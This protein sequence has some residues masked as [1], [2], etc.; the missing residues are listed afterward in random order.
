M[1]RVGIL[2]GGQ[3]GMLLAN[4]IFTLGGRVNVFDPDPEAPACNHVKNSIN[5]PWMNYDALNNFFDISD[6][7]TYE[8]EN[9]ESAPLVS[10]GHLKPIYPS[11]KVLKTCQDR[12]LEKK[13]L[14][15]AGLPHAN[16]VVADSVAHL[17]AQANHIN[18]PCIVKTAR[19]GYDGKGQFKISSREEY[20][21]FL[22]DPKND[23][24]ETFTGVV[25]EVIEL[26]TE[27]S[28]I[29]ARPLNGAPVAFPILENIHKEHILDVTVLPARIPNSVQKKIKEIAIEAATKLD[30]C[31]LLTTEFFLSK[32]KSATSPGI[33][34]DGWYIYINE[35]APRPH[36]SGHVT[37]SACCMSQY[38]AL[39]RILLD[40]PL[41]EPLV[42]STGTFC[43]MNLLG[44]V[45]LA[46]GSKDYDAKL[47]LSALRD[48]PQVLDVVIYGK[49]EPR[50]KRK[51]GHFITYGKTPESAIEAAHAF[52]NSLKNIKV[53]AS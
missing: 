32:T 45:W 2:G 18:F 8:F 52:R 5:F 24:L 44:D 50:A 29:V 33:E 42:I 7:V 26:E 19:G 22:D 46:Q 3:L 28:C 49:R 9:V 17:R 16:F 30:V 14:L 1:K 41:Q 48:H 15:A 11:V 43:M 37:T 40:V 39:A 21:A 31:G 38:D 12:A 10:L 23:W 27:V 36:N 53:T 6:V 47:D 4:S 51:M 34:C 13:F 25:E 20:L 35:F